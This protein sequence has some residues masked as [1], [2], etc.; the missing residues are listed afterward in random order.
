MQ[1]PTDKGQLRSFIGCVQYF[2][3]HLGMD[4]AALTK[5]LTEMTKKSAAFL[6]AAEHQ[7]CFDEINLLLRSLI[8]DQYP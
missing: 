1:A 6:W 3:E 8:K 5:P 7:E 2:R 4:A